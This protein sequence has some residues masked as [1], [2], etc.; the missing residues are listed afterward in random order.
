MNRWYKR[1]LTAWAMLSFAFL[2]GPIVIIIPMSFSDTNYITFP[3]TGFSFRWYY[4]FLVG[5][6][7]WIRSTIFS[8]QIGVVAMII[9]TVLGTGLAFAIVRSKLLGFEILEK[10]IPA[11]LVL[12]TI[13]YTISIYYLFAEWRFTGNILSIAIPHAIMALPYV[14]ILLC[15]GLRE[16]DFRQEL[17]AYGMGAGRWRTMRKVILPQLYPSVFS[18]ALFA[19]MTSFDD[20][21]VALFLSSGFQPTLP[22]KMYEN[23]RIDIDPTISAVS[24]IQVVFILVFGS[25]AV[26]WNER[27]R[28][29][30]LIEE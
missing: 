10:F 30:T 22:Q 29:R 26:H 17:A 23:I 13:I 27:V 28:K 18:A 5:D 1:A 16:L 8:V 21:V 14:V 24:V 25:L 15:A 9:S 19:F 6:P 7:S 12:P 4:N 2:L 3:P 20:L 11:P